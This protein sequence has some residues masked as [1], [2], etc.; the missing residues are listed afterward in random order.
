MFLKFA[1]IVTLCSMFIGSIMLPSITFGNGWSGY[2]QGAKS[3]GMGNAFTGLADDP[4][5][6][7]YNPAGI[8]QL[9]G[10]QFSLGFAIPM[11]SG[12]FKSNGTSGMVDDTAGKTTDLDTQFVFIP[13]MYFTSKLNDKIT[14]GIGQYTVFGLGFK[15]PDSF[16]GRYAPGGKNGEIQTITLSPVVGYKVTDKLSVAVGV[17]AERA[18]M[19]LENK[20]FIAPGVDD[21]ETKISGADYGFGWN[22]S[23]LYKYMDNLSFGLNYRSK[24]NHSFNDL[25]FEFNPQIAMVGI[26]NT[27]ADMDISLP[28]YAS[29]GLAWEKGPWTWT[30]DG[31][32]WDWSSEDK[33]T[34]KLNTPVAGQSTITTAMDWHDTMSWAI[35]TQ[36]KTQLLDRDVCFRGGFMYDESPA[37]DKTL[38]PSGFHGDNLLYNL[39]VGFKLGPFYNDLHLTYV[40]TKDKAWNNDTGNAPNPGGG[41]VTG[42]FQNY[43]TFIFGSSLTYKF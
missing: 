35:G 1:R 25:D 37:P 24:I 39:G 32:W 28:Q 4:S 26:T 31:Y 21:V 2:L 20:T 8:V 40:Y 33:M 14:L 22:T 38:N 3:N 43:N 13:N 23:L 34:F 11:V 36:Y 7:F 10:N 15:W 27:N 19:I 9:D 41:Q 5:A 29:F 12:E 6:V 17:C 30:M 42:E 18:N 16:D